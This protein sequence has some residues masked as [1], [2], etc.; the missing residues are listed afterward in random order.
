MY[1]GRR[2]KICPALNPEKKTVEIRIFMRRSSTM[3]DEVL[4]CTCEFQLFKTVQVK[5]RYMGFWQKNTQPDRL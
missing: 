3:Y 2:L 1:W 4:L 5:N